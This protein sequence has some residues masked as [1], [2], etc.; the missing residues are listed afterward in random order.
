MN[1]EK[2]GNTRF[3]PDWIA[4]AWEKKNL[5]QGETLY[6]L[7]I[8]QKTINKQLSLLKLLNKVFFVVSVIFLTFFTVVG[9]AK[10][11]GALFFLWL[12]LC[13][14][15]CPLFIYRGVRLLHSKEDGYCQRL[16][17][18]DSMISI[19]W[20]DFRDLGR[21]FY[22]NREEVK[23]F[24]IF[25]AVELLIAESNIKLVRMNAEKSVHDLRIVM[26]KEKIR[27]ESFDHVWHTVND[28]FGLFPELSREDVFRL[29]NLK[30]SHVR[31][32]SSRVIIN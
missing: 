19:F 18:V 3:V 24:L 26:N 14:I 22:T 32:L 28:S 10:F 31:H 5:I 17:R 7:S 8:E 23:D 21:V 11:S 25:E 30:L 20:N 15:A 13:A 9:M 6:D 4:Q 2:D 1:I 27:R 16:C 29:A 12:V